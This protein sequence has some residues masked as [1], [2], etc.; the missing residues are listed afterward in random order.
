MS[1][2]SY[3]R[4]Q[5]TAGDLEDCA[6]ALIELLDKKVTPLSRRELEAA[7]D[8][9]AT[10]QRIVDRV[11]DENSTDRDELDETEIGGV[12]DHANAKADKEQEAAYE[13]DRR[14]DR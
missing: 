6:D 3:C 7:K 9:V 14:D 1:N 5:N 10:C 13:S 8:L 2:M 4:F 11:A 12:L